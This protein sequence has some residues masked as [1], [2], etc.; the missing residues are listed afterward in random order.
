MNTNTLTVAIS[1]DDIKSIGSSHA[2]MESFRKDNIHRLK[3]LCNAAVLIS[4]T[5]ETRRIVVPDGFSW[6]LDFLMISILMGDFGAAEDC[7]E[8]V[9]VEGQALIVSIFE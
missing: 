4:R 5:Y 3:E 9:R 7:R 1:A 8:F 2:Y 6:T